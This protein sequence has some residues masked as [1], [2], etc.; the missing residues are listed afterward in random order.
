MRDWDKL[1]ISKEGIIYRKTSDNNQLLLP[2]KF[3]QLVY[4]ELDCEMGH[5]SSERAIDLAV[6]C[7]YW[8]YMRQNIEVFITNHL[9]CIKQKSPHGKGIAPLQNIIT[10]QPFPLVSIDFLHL[11]KSAGGF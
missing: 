10:T 9:S 8:P 11:E 6:Q 3:H 1:Y 5:L 7:F 2:M 4:Q